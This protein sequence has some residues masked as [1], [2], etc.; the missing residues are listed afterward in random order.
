DRHQGDVALGKA[1]LLRRGVLAGGHAGQDGQAGLDRLPSA[2]RAASGASELLSSW[3]LLSA[4]PWGWEG[5]GLMTGVPLHA[6]SRT[7]VRSSASNFFIV[8]PPTVWYRGSPRWKRSFRRVFRT[9]RGWESGRLPP[10]PGSTGRPPS[11]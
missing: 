2:G 6:V 1:G 3:L 9:R 10:A 8:L 4:A 7:A 11:R 5:D